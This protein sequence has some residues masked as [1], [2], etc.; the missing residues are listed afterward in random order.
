MTETR[1]SRQGAKQASGGQNGK[2]RSPVRR[3]LTWVLFTLLG[4]FALGVLGI[5]IAYARIQIPQPNELANA[6]VSIVYYDDGKTEMGRMADASGN[7]EYVTLAQVP[8]HVQHAVLAA[9]DRSF[10][11]NPGVS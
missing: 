3:V 6:Q 1:S 10:Y 11:D 2:R 7:R 5:A 8:Q 9:E 4:L